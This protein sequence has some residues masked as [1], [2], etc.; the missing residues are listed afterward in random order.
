M[1]CFKLL[2]NFFPCGS[3]RQS[4]EVVCVTVN[5][6]NNGVFI[7]SISWKRKAW[8]VNASKN[9]WHMH[10]GLCHEFRTERSRFVT[11]AHLKSVKTA[12]GHF[13]L[14]SYFCNYLYGEQY[15]EFSVELNARD[16]IAYYE[17]P[18]KNGYVE[19]ISFDASRVVD[20]HNLA[21]SRQRIRKLIVESAPFR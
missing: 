7:G 14:W 3:D 1:N 12:L 16:P 6:T 11:A 10:R 13:V 17:A 9:A 15:H 19:Y 2:D 8:Y 20:M 21:R 4:G 18:G 5:F